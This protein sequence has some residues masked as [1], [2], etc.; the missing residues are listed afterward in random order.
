[1]LKI[2]KTWKKTVSVS[3]P[4]YTSAMYLYDFPSDRTKIF[5]FVFTCQ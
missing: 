5:R 3:D 4:H 1:M 2:Y